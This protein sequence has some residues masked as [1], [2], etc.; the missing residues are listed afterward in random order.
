MQWAFHHLVMFD[1]PELSTQINWIVILTAVVLVCLSVVYQL[2]TR[3]AP[4]I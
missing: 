2:Q 1:R 3:E 4:D